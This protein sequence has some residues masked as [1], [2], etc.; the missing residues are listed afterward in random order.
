MSSDAQCD[1]GVKEGINTVFTT[2]STLN[3]LLQF[4]LTI[5]LHIKIE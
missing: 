3:S 4:F 5:A 1:R 2:L